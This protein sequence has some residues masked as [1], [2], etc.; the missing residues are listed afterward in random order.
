MLFEPLTLQ[1]GQHVFKVTGFTD[2]GPYMESFHSLDNYFESLHRQ[3]TDIVKNP[4]HRF[5]ELNASTIIGRML[6]IGVGVSDHMK[7]HNL[8]HT[9]LLRT[10]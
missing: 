2:F 3:L 4:N 10:H 9:M 7:V 5:M 6:H 1:S 8:F